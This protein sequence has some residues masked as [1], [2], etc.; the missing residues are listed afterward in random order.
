VYG[1]NWSPESEFVSEIK[2][3]LR[4]RE[5]DDFTTSEELKEKSN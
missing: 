1:A 4:G 5:I 2:A 3:Q